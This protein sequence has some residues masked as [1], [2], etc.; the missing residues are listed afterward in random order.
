MFGSTQRVNNNTVIEPVTMDNDVVES[1]SSF[2]YLGILLDSDLNFKSHA[3]YLRRKVFAKLKVLSR[4]RQYISINLALYLY[5]SLI[6]PEFDY[7]DQIYD[8]MATCTSNQL[9][10]LQNSCLHVCTKADKRMPIDELH[11][12]SGITRFVDR[13]NMHTCNFVHNGL[14]GQL[15]NEVNRMFTHTANDRAIETRASAS[16]NLNVTK[17]KLKVSKGNIAIQGTRYLMT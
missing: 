16:G 17:C 7:G 14:Q 6:L 13:R 3:A 1:V 9:Q 12:I 11:K 4:V 10:V 5:K 2:K 8:A 15:S